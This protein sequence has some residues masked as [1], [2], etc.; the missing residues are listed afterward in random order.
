[1]NKGWQVLVAII[2]VLAIYGF[3]ISSIILVSEI[4]KKKELET[5]IAEQT[6]RIEALDDKVERYRREQDALVYYYTTEQWR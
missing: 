4:R 1:M 5:I 6:E 2:S 3:L